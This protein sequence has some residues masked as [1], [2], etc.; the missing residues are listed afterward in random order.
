MSWDRICTALALTL[1]LLGAVEWLLPAK[2]HGHTPFWGEIYSG[3]GLLGAVSCI[4]VVVVSKA[5]G[6]HLLQRPEERDV[7]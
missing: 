3:Y 7:P 6:K 1:V 2:E 5:L 4:V